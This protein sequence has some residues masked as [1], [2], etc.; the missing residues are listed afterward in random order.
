MFDLSCK[1]AADL[2]V[3]SFQVDSLAVRG[4]LGMLRVFWTKD[5]FRG[6]HAK[7]R[8]WTLIYER[9]HRPSWN[10]LVPLVLPEPLVV[11]VGA[12][13]GL[14][15]HSSESNDESIVYDNQRGHNG[16]SDAFITILPGYDIM[17]LAGSF[18]GF[19]A[20]SSLPAPQPR[21]VTRRMAHLGFTPFA[22]N[23]PWG[24]GGWRDRR[25][26][27]GRVGYSVRYKLWS[28]KICQ[29]FPAEFRRSAVAFVN[30]HIFSWKGLPMDVVVYILNMLHPGC[31]C[32]SP[33]CVLLVAP[34]AS[35]SAHLPLFPLPFRPPCCRWFSSDPIQSLKRAPSTRPALMTALSPAASLLTALT[36][37]TTSAEGQEQL[38][39]VN[40]FRR[41]CSRCVVS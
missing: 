22:N 4:G 23:A 16:H 1:N 36:S 7:P 37:T 31:A 8:E 17:C 40:V 15:V 30:V 35:P 19:L 2:P 10:E 41:W 26:F 25:Q 38:V 6:T 9:H 24:G 28:P 32:I 18:L 21:T 20:H 14:Y 11:P 33:Q 39:V 3:D 27:V 29:H 13:V 5:T 12:S 34:A